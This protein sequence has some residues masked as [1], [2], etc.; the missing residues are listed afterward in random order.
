MKKKTLGIIL[1]VIGILA[2]VGALSNG[3][4]ANYANVGIGLSDIVTI[5][6][7]IGAVI[8]GLVLIV[9]GDN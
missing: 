9:K 1:L 6:L 8:V 7:E 5:A 4:F 3:T 2:I